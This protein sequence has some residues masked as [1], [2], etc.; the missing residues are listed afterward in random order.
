MTDSIETNDPLRALQ[1][2][3]RELEREL[4]EHRQ[5]EQALAESERRQREIARLLELDQAKLAAVLRHLPVGVWIT[6]A[7]GRVIGSNEAA[8]RIWAGEPP[9]V[10]SIDEFQAYVARC[11]GSSK[12]LQPEEYPVAV[13][14]R[15]GKPVENRELEIRRFDGSEG[16]VMV[17]AAPIRDPQGR[18]AGTVSVNVDITERK[19]LEE[20]LRE[21]QTMLADAERISDVGSWRWN[22]RTGEVRWSDELYRLYAVDRETFAPSIDSF[23]NFIHPDDR[24]LVQQKIE[25][26]TASG[27][28]VDFEFRIISGIGRLRILR[29]MGQ[30][31]ELDENGNPLI[32]IGA[33][34]DV[35]EQRKAEQ[36]LRESEAKFHSAFE[37]AA[38]GYALQTPEGRFLDANAAYCKLMGYSVDELQQ[39]HFFEFLHQEDY[40]HHMQLVE[41]LLEGEIPD[42]VV[43]SRYYRKDGRVVW[44]RKSC[45]LVKEANGKPKWMLALLEDITES[46][47]AERARQESENI[48]RA[49][50]EA[51][52]YGI[53]ICEPDGR[54]IYASQ[55]FLDL[56]GITQQQ[57][58]DFGWGDTLHPDDAERTIAAWKECVRTEGIWDIE[59]R[60]RGTDGQYH[61][62]LARGI[63][64]RDEHGKILCWAGINLDISRLKQA[65]H[66]LKTSEERFAVALKNS[67]MLVSTSDRDLRYTWIY[68]PPM[69]ME[70]SDMIGKRDEEL[71][72]PENVRELVALKRSVLD[73]GIGRRTE[74][75]WRYQA[76]VYYY[77]VTA[78]PV[79][80]ENGAVTGLTVAA[81]DVTEKKRIEQVLLEDRVRIELQRRLLEQREEERLA[82]AQD[83]HDGPTQTLASVMLRLDIAR[84]LEISPT[85]HEEFDGI[86]ADIRKVVQELREIIAELRPPLLQ[87]L[88]LSQAMRAYAEDFRSKYPEIKL[89]Q[90]IA[91]DGEQL[92]TDACLSLFRIYQE[93]LNN[94]V[95]HAEATRAQVR[96]AF[97]EESAVLEIEDNGKGMHVLPDLISQTARGH[98]GMAG[99]HERAKAV[100]GTLQVRSAPGQGT[101]VLATIPVHPES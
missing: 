45:S 6:D 30:V 69:G 8:E 16:T 39:L 43:E 17:S 5:T 77:D 20:A 86:E 9:P 66:D 74:I 94:I 73:S 75:E 48:Y 14:L 67:P 100:G 57:C 76:K 52:P 80:D 25:Q 78:E 2:R 51:I 4:E 22:I 33:N 11:P 92:S 1:A 50:G 46:K 27:I 96:L 71:N 35:T 32:M 65:Q 58:S 93:A 10:N 18:I 44:I 68:N 61:P 62:I 79:R 7:N 47:Q 13:A 101:S 28:P 56:V 95:H 42:F 31:T 55:S 19:R 41:Q 37:H 34:Q 29:T 70:A 49:I 59:H 83:I 87:L 12:P 60:F 53:W 91:D 97:V 15:T 36:A 72:D 38:I 84:E 23:A 98:Y 90:E 54:N 99:M 64:V 81:I 26:I 88:G 3:I 24:L 21:H 89:T 40:Y 85:L 63:P 82:V